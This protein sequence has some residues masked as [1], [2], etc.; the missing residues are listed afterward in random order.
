[1]SAAVLRVFICAA[2][3]GLEA[4]VVYVAVDAMLTSTAVMATRAPFTQAMRYS[5]ASVAVTKAVEPSFF[6]ALNEVSTFTCLRA[7][8]SALVAADAEFH[9][10]VSETRPVLPPAS[11][12]TASTEAVQP[13]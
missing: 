4:T 1:M 13:F 10:R 12:Y 8:V 11:S 9:C 7:L 3:R 2:V 6:G 5:G